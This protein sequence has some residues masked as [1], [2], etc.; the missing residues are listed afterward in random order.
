[1]NNRK[2]N[3]QINKGE[4][5]IYKK[6]G[7]PMLQVKV[8]KETVWL[9]QEQISLLFG[10]ERSVITKHLRNIFK[11]S[12]LKEN[13]VCAKIAH[14]AADGK[15]YQTQFYN[16]DV[17]IS[18]GYRVNSKRA[19]EFRIWA[20]RVLKE[21]L[22]RGYTVNQRRL[23]E[24]GLSEFE[25][26]IKLLKTTME[27]K[28][29]NSA[30]AEGLLEIITKYSEAWLLLQKY[31]EN[32]IIAPAKK[33]KAKKELSYQEAVAAIKEL[34]LSL[35][36]KRQA[37]DLFGQERQTMLQG[38]ARGIEQKFGGKELYPT[39]EDKAAHLLYFVIKDH[40]FIDGNKR[41]AS[42]LFLVF[43][44]KNNYDVNKKGE[45]K[46]NSNALVALALLIAES[47]PEQ[48]EVMIKLIMNFLNN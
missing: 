45:Y 15:V 46:F 34:K 38:I 35:L 9:T 5:V 32:K 29:L 10:V 40:P 27:S 42:L 28:R 43:L 30:E 2:Q 8:E 33:A 47:R 26:A 12:E 3:S 1:M 6:A 25:Q 23:S 18:V 17:I 11:S 41:I 44:R 22:I 4:I 37:S 7:K 21:H 16:L 48:K 13:S 31:D 20:T 24:T 19:T 14:T 36:G 39:I